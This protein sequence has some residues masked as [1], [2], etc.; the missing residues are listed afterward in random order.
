V[1]ILQFAPVLAQYRHGPGTEDGELLGQYHS[2]DALKLVP[3]SM[4][5]SHVRGF[6][7]INMV[8]RTCFSFSAPASVAAAMY[9]V[10]VGT[11]I[12]Y[13]ILGGRT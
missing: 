9:P 5:C 2:G 1:A 7:T 10:R 8:A 4:H 6:A 3:G 12:G 11:P 13:R